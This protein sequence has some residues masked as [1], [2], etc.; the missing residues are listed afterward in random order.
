MV[1][2]TTPL[3]AVV[4]AHPTYFLLVHLRYLSKCLNMLFVFCSHRSG[5]MQL[6]LPTGWLFSLV[7]WPP[8]KGHI[9]K[10]EKSRF[11][12]QPCPS[13]V[14]RLKDHSGKGKRTLS[15]NSSLFWMKIIIC[16]LN[17]ARVG[18]AFCW[19]GSLAK[20]CDLSS[21]KFSFDQAIWSSC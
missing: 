18:S 19:I 9:T 7:T 4:S 2:A 6:G 13:P 8:C 20:M 1:S 14:T 11:I 10:F 5:R 12:R 3:T 21:S 16:S 17:S 15:T